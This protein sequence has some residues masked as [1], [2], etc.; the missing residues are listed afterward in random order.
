MPQLKT[1]NRTQP[2]EGRL[3]G[4]G[5]DSRLTLQVGTLIEGK[6]MIL[7]F[8]GKG[9]MG[10]VYRAQQLSLKRDVAVKIVS[11]EWLKSFDCDTEDVESSLE[12]FRREVQIMAQ[13]HH[14]NILQVFDHGTA[15]IEKGGSTVSLEYIVMELV[16]GSTLRT[17]MSEEGFEPDE[18]RMK[19]WLSDYFLAVL[20]GIKALHER[21]IIHRDIKPEN[22]LL[23]GKVPKIADFGLARSCVSKPITRSAHVMGTAP[24]MAQEQFLDMRRTDER[25]DVYALG[26]ILYEAASGKIGP[27]QMPF[28]QAALKKPEG[29]F[30]QDL[31]RLIRHA[32]AEDKKERLP[33]VEEFRRH[34]EKLIEEPPSNPEVVPVK[35]IVAVSLKDI[36]EK[37][38]VL[39]S[40]ILLLIA[41]AVVA[42]F[43][44]SWQGRDRALRQA[45]LP[46]ELETSPGISTEDKSAVPSVSPPAAPS[47]PILEQRIMGADEAALHLVPGGKV[48][49]PL[50]LRADGI[51]E[52]EVKSFYMDTTPVTIH[53]YVDFLNEVLPRITVSDGVV[54][55]DDNIWL[56]LG[57]VAP[58]FDPIVF[59]DGMFH[60]TIAH[61]ASCPVLRVTA[62]GASAY[63]DYYGRRLPTV[64]EWLRAAE[65]STASGVAERKLPIPSPVMEYKPNA[66][67]IGGLNANIGEWGM[68]RSMDKENG[69]KKADA[70]TAFAVLGGIPDPSVEKAGL[71]APISRF[72][73]EAFQR[74][75]FRCVK[76]AGEN[77]EA[78]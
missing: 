3:S 53:Q 28:K 64:A 25:A 2:V 47:A 68:W 30:Y 74:V 7:E 36:A 4:A 39:V 76:D 27:D 70:Q 21:G 11:R 56:F 55:G 17:T 69:D 73:W 78:G 50:P 67:G 38:P 40:A 1:E 65:P 6:W 45:T 18:D 52:I 16:P 12:R 43:V 42:L 54:K 34:I 59:K 37:R 57:E 71:G 23:A 63:A 31:D 61:H 62:Y 5:G 10:E 35:T 58:G 32:T 49:L 9:G 20:E 24:Y 44:M 19:E 75:G 48:D 72:P 8:I 33:T 41:A 66:Y 14:P 22:I 46:A 26:K 13:V 60:L 29:L 77:R 51:R 15:Q